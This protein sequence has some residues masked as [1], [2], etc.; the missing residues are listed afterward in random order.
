MAFAPLT[1]RTAPVLPGP[2]PSSDIEA[3][4]DI[5]LR[6]K[7]FSRGLAARPQQRLKPGGSSPINTGFQALGPAG[8]TGK[9]D[10]PGLQGNGRYRVL[11][12]EP[13]ETALS[14][15]TGYIDGEFHIKRDP[16]AG[17]DVL[18][19]AGR[20]WSRK[21]RAW[22]PARDQCF[23]ICLSYDANRDVGRISWGNDIDESVSFSRGGRG[24]QMTVAFGGWSHDFYQD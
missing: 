23:E 21:T 17:K 18:R 12:N 3:A 10:G 16:A 11:K 8:K 14:V 20:Y 22:E 4:Q 15:R 6:M 5:I 1:A 24:R 13:F 7:D 2:F 19:F 9:V